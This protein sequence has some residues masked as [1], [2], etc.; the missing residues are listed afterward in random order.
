VT[1]TSRQRLFLSYFAVLLTAPA[2][3]R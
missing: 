2:V 3:V 1:I